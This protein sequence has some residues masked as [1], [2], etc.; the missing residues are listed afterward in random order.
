M[1]RDGS[2]NEAPRPS[3]AMPGVEVPTAIGRH[4]ATTLV[5]DAKQLKAFEILE[6]GRVREIGG[7]AELGGIPLAC[8]M[9]SGRGWLA[10]GR[11]WRGV[12][13]PTDFEIAQLKSGE[14][15][16]RRLAGVEPDAAALAVMRAVLPYGSCASGGAGET[17]LVLNAL[18][19]V[20][21]FDKEGSLMAEHVLPGSSTAPVVGLRGI[22][23]APKS[24]AEY[25]KLFDGK[26][27][28]IGVG[29]SGSGHLVAFAD[30]GKGAGALSVAA[31]DKDGRERGVMA[32]LDVPCYDSRDFLMAAFGTR[33]KHRSVVVLTIPFAEGR[34][35]KSR[36]LYQFQVQESQDGPGVGVA[37]EP[38][39]GGV[40]RS[41]KADLPNH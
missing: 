38:R 1:L 37:I 6:G 2:G 24:P 35:A 11:M 26:R 12:D 33:G 14:E 31:F 28:P 4:G 13:A 36:Y 16:T 8:L 17:L 27:I 22:R 32:Y 34:D 39:P 30:L 18:D 25:Q 19:R 15:P 10:A 3:L 29:S 20:F 23:A 21:R 41:R 9:W 40:N 5:F 7:P